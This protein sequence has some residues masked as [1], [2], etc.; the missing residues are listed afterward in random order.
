MFQGISMGFENSHNSKLVTSALKKRQAQII[1]RFYSMIFLCACV[2]EVVREE[3]EP[4]GRNVECKYKNFEKE[5]FPT[6][7]TIWRN[8][9]VPSP[10]IPLKI[11][12]WTKRCTWWAYVMWILCKGMG[13]V[14]RSLTLR[15]NRNSASWKT[16]YIT[17]YFLT[18]LTMV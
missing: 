18:V 1:F 7:H 17:V 2:K 8:G 3:W 14:D 6:I 16:D 13:K 11:I 9:C 5:W 10:S 4:S 15:L 12:T